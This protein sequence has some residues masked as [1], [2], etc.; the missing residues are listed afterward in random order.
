MLDPRGADATVEVV[1]LEGIYTTTIRG[2]VTARRALELKAIVDLQM[3]DPRTR[4]C[5]VDIRSIVLAFDLRRF[6]WGPAPA[7]P[8]VGLRPRAI[9]VNDGAEGAM[10]AWVALALP[11]RLIGVFTEPASALSWTRD[12]VWFQTR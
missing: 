7:A 10:R 9:V 11:D 12:R 2:V 1:E 3:L 6:A 4:G 5:I 8:R